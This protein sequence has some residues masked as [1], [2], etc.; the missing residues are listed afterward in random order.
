[1]RDERPKWKLC[2]GTAPARGGRHCQAD[3]QAHPQQVHLNNNINV[4]LF[5]MNFQL[6]CE[7]VCVVKHKDALIRQ[8][9][10]CDDHFVFYL[11]G[12]N[13][14]LWRVS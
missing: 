1:M 7:C 11:M 6:S 9:D 14:S 4:L 8:N 5:T 3:G 2:D 10:F 13:T 12:Y